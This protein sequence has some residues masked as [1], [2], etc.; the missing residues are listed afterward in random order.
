MMPSH[1]DDG[2]ALQLQPDPDKLFRYHRQQLS[3]MLDGELSPDQA[4]FM[5]RR[6]DHDTELADCWA[7]WQVC[8]DVLRGRHHALLPADFAAGVARAVAD[9]ARL[10][11]DAAAAAPSADR[12]SVGRRAGILRWGGGAALVA[13]VAMV[14]LLVGRQTSTL[15]GVEPGAG[16]VA[17]TGA[18]TAPPASS[19]P[20]PNGSGEAPSGAIDAGVVALAGASA[21]AIAE[22]PRRDERRSRGQSQRAA[23]TRE[24]RH[25]EPTRIAASAPVRV[26]PSAPAEEAVAFALPALASESSVASPRPWPRAGLGSTNPFAAS[27]G[28]AGGAANE[29]A[30]SFH[31]FEPRIEDASSRTLQVAGAPGVSETAIGPLRF[32]APPPAAP[33][34][35]DVSAGPFAPA[36]E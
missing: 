33:S 13:S 15:Q 2:D 9:G 32:E 1:P 14:A 22:V 30:M 17:V 34:S 11:D 31:P 10:P 18:A 12:R 26:S 35:A 3:A 23:A 21:L 7:R 19:T 16:Q 8:G 25:A 24:Q 27:Y 29:G 6:L 20:A 28:A 4:R 5:L 36:T